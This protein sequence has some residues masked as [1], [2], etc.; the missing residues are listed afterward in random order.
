M[1]LEP[2]LKIFQDYN[3]YHFMGKTIPL[4]CY[5]R[6]KDIFLYCIPLVHCIRFEKYF[7]DTPTNY[8]YNNNI[9]H[10]N[11]EIATSGT[12]F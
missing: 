2:V 10:F 5:S 1:V 3:K 11:C 8:H 6:E 9:E 12:P 7:T 4:C